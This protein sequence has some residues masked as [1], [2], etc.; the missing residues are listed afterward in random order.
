M[1]LIEKIYWDT[2]NQ[3]STIMLTKVLHVFKVDSKEI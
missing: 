3:L 1:K 2:L